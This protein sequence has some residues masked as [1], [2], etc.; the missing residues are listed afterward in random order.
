MK[1]VLITTDNFKD[2]ELYDTSDIEGIKEY[3]K[4]ITEGTIN[5]LDGTKHAY[6]GSQDDMTPEQ[7]REA[8]ETIIYLSDIEKG[9]E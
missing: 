8:A 1:R 7:A 9:V 3:A 5:D 6:I 2:F 4:G